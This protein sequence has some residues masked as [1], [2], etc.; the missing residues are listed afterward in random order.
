MALY[1]LSFCFVMKG[2]EEGIFACTI[3]EEIGA[4][5]LNMHWKVHD[6]S[7]WMIFQSDTAGH[8]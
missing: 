3:F 5:L 7:T 6:P 4:S 2:G 1:P 8:S